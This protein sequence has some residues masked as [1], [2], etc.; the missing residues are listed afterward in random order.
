MEVGETSAQAGMSENA[1]P[2][3]TAI[4]TK[5]NQ[6]QRLWELRTLRALISSRSKRLK[7][8]TTMTSIL[9]FETNVYSEELHGVS[10]SEYDE[11]MQMMADEQSGFEG[12]GE[13][14]QSLEVV[15]ES[16]NFIAYS[17]GRVNHR[18][19]PKSNGRYQG[20]EI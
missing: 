9:T 19:E 3:T 5:L 4:I 13:W 1:N 15:A 17:D 16:E 10:E 2:L 11:V 8:N 20:I 7:R 18:P 6:R 14:S 12:Y